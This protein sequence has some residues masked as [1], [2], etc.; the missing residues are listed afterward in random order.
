M[1]QPTQAG[2]SARPS[3]SPPRRARRPWRALLTTAVTTTTVL[4]GA[5]LVPATAATSTTTAAFSGT[6]GTTGTATRGGVLYAKANAPLT[7][8]V[9]APTDTQCITGVPA[10]FTGETFSSSGKSLW[11]FTGTAQGGDGSRTFTIGASGANKQGNCSGQSSTA[12]PSYTS[13]NTGPVVTAALS[14][15]ANVAG[16]NRDNTT[17]TWSASDAGSG[18]GTGPSPASSTESG[19]GTATRTSTATDAVGNSG[20]GSVVVRIDKAAPSITAAQVKNP[21]G[22]VTVTFTCDDSNSGNE[23]SGIASCL[24]NGSTTNSVI[25][26]KSGDVTGTATDKAG[27]TA[28]TKV[29]VQAG[30]TSAPVLSGAPTTAPNGNGWYA[31]DVKIHWTASDP[32]SGI[33]T[34]PADTTITGEGSG[35]TSSVTVTNGAGLSTTATSSP[36]VSIDR[37]A[38]TTGITGPSNAWTNGDVTVTL[39]PKDGGSGV[40]KTEYSVDGGAFQTGTSFPLSTEGTHAVTYRSTDRAGNVEALQSATVKIDKSAPTIGHAFDPAGYVDGSW[41]NQD[42]TVTFVCTDQGGSAVADCSAPVTKTAEGEHSVTGTARDGA[43]N[44]TTDT[45]TVRIDKTAPTVT[46]TAVGTKNDAG[47]YRDDVRVVYTANDDRS[48]LTGSPAADVLGEG[49]GQSAGTTVT[50]A[51]GN[52]ASA[53]VAN[54]DVDKTPPVLGAAVPAGWH[55]GAVT[56]TW[57][58]TDTLSGVAQKPAA[59]VVSGEGDN[60]SAT[61]SCT[62]MAGNTTVRTVDG[63]KIDGT[64]PVTTAHVGDANEAN[65]YDAP[66]EV[67]LHGVD[68]LGGTVATYYRI[69]EGDAQRY[70]GPFSVGEGEHAVSY[71]SE[72][73]AG[74]AEK[75][76]T[77]LTLQVDGTAPKTEVVN[78]ISPDSGWF[79]KSGIPVAFKA[80]DAGSGVA[81]TYYEVDE[82]DTQ[83]YGGPFTANLSDGTHSITYWSVD[84]AGNVEAKSTTKT[85]QVDTVA[86]SI[87][88]KSTPAANPNGWNNT[89]VDVTF[90]CTDDGSG[91]PEESQ[92]GVAG[93]AGDTTLANDGAGQVAPGDAVDVAGNTSHTTVGPINIDTVE[94]TL[95]GV[96]PDPSGTDRDGLAWYRGDVA[97]RWVGD[98]ALSKIDPASQPA[99]SVVEGEGKGLVTDPASIRDKA[100]NESAPTTVRGINIDRT[101]PVVAG[102]PTTEPNAAGWYQNSVIV[103]YTCSD[104]LSGVATCPTSRLVKGDGADQSVTSDP[105]R[106]VAGNVSAGTTV[107][108]INIDGTAPSTTANNTCVAENDWCKGDTA[109][110]VLT[111]ADQAGLSGVKE[112]RYSI[113]GGAEQVVAGGRTTVSV[114]LTGSGAGTVKFYAVDNAGNKETVNGVALKWDN[115]APT[116]TH[117]LSPAANAGGWNNSDVTVAFAAKDDDKGSGVASISAPVTVTDETVG[118]VVTG[119]AKDTAGNVG[120]DSV[121]VKLDKTK[122]TITGAVT[123]GTKGDNGWY[124]GPVTV[125]FSCS[126]SLSGVATCPDPVVLSANGENNTATGTATDKAGNTATTTLGGVKIDQEKPTLTTGDVNVQGG[127]YTLGS[128]PT[129]TCTASDS[130]SGLASCT[131]K[132]TGGNANGTGT[133]SY[134]ATATDRAGNTSQVS[135]TFQVVYKFGGFLQP[136]NDTAHQ[137][138]TSTSIFKSGSTVPAKFQLAKADGTPV[139]ATTAPVWLAP[140]KGSSTAAPVDETVYT[141]SADSGTTYRYDTTAQQYIY[142]WKTGTGGNYW[143]IGVRLDDGQ[144]YYVNIGLR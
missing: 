103:D 22:S 116:V 23:G 83:K 86:P 108:G 12:T 133:F 121:T 91:I 26:T 132:V 139:Q 18:V 74:N 65:W 88:G 81:A 125:T 90:T 47:W 25:V 128:V 57:T 124:V 15:A 58:C 1:S 100:G 11:T 63:I 10:G 61:A 21:D 79:V 52:S 110:V 43:G 142:N 50:D 73:A 7:L 4:G 40:A 127:T 140:V 5:A 92:T 31:G 101:A 56:V 87:T 44:T 8:T 144:T 17:V 49:R 30:D 9:N 29:T 98:D 117:T 114:P 67:T 68:N 135:G 54:I 38:P 137:V 143:R 69:D 134:T 66:V 80:T 64:A 99:D 120:T 109:D 13:D 62:D 118:R 136:I 96:L 71:W 28:S 78:P 48:G 76:G 95:A 122:P 102:A 41:T 84:L 19:N 75:P 55:T 60:L 89:P 129:A 6:A 39:S 53:R 111:A 106:D 112:I 105:A 130:F 119:T 94:P 46:A 107:G 32:E 14:P 126:D 33:P 70:D 45:A 82:G 24:V 16:W 131:V 2:R 59:T 34:A 51:A 35:L 36:A 113:D 123:S 138:G 93:C 77:P 72:D 97:V 20:S 141:A 27:N 37:T 115:I 3:S 104:R 85:I 42:V